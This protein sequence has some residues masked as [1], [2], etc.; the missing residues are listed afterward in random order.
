MS[1]YS[2]ILAWRTQWTEEPADCSQ[3]DHKESDLVTE[4]QR[5]SI[6]HMYHIFIHSFVDGHQVVSHLGTVNNATKTCVLQKRPL[7]ISYGVAGREFNVNELTVSTNKVS[8]SKHTVN[9][10]L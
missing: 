8:L 4:Q 2:G 3:W 6:V 9:K 1:A 10:V 5:Y 7:G